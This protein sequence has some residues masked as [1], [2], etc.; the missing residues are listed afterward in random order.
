MAPAPTMTAA[1]AC[2]SS[3]SFSGSGTTVRIAAKVSAA[4]SG[5]LPG[6]RRASA[7][8]TT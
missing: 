8:S 7:P 1:L 2:T 3:V 6:E 5:R 4:I